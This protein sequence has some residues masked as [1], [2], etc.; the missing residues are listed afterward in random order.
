M[1]RRKVNIEDR[2]FNEEWREKSFFNKHFEKPTCLVC[3]YSVS[4][5]K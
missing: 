4:L 5:N 3:N 1:K 2:V